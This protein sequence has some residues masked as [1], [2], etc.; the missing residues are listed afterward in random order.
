MATKIKVDEL[1]DTVVGW[2][3]E[4]SEEVTEVAKDVVDEMSQGV[5]QETKSHIS[6]KNK[7]YAQSFA[8]K[9]S[10]EDRRNKRNTW[11]VKSPHYRLT[12]LLEYGHLTR[13]KTGKYGEQQR[14]KEY[15]HVRYGNEFLKDNFERVMREKIEQCK[16]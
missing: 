12:H 14:T 10:F 8:I 4:Y 3:T 5:M 15:P 7:K 16:I 2:L 13:Y 11:Y 1:A 6:W 9:T